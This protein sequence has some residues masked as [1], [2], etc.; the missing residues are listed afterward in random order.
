M[1][2][3]QFVDT[4][5]GKKVEMYDPSN[6]YQCVDLVLAWIKEQGCGSLI[7]LGIMNAYELYTKTPKKVLEYYTKIENTLEAIPQAGDIPVWSSGYGPA[8][9][10]AVC[11][12]WAGQTQFEAFS[13]NDPIGAPCIIKRY[14]YDNILGWLRL[15]SAFISENLVSQGVISDG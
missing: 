14:N 6:K 1:T 13:Q 8:G 10:T 2:I 7:P 15:L 9:H 12:G 11:T 5:R 3:E 4:W